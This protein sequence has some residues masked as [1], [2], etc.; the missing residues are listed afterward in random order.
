MKCII[1]C[2]GYDNNLSSN[3]TDDIP[4]GLLELSNE[5]VLLDS[6][7]EQLSNLSEL[8]K[9]Y[10]VTN[11]KYYISFMNWYKKTI[12]EKDIVIVNDNT[13]SKEAKLG[14][15]GDIKFVINSENIDDDILVLLG[16]ALFDFDINEFINYYRTYQVPIVA[17]LESN[18]IDPA[19]Y[20]VIKC[21]ASDDI[22]L[23]QEKPT[24]VFG[25][26]ISLGLYLFPKEILREFDNYLSAGNKA[27]SPGYFIE[28]LY[29]NTQIK[30][31]KIHG[32]YIA[33]KD[34]N[35]LCKAKETYAKRSL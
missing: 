23:M 21:T 11:D 8:D 15:I 18:N 32:S 24:K 4:S 27:T 22:K 14:A 6:T 25:N 2:A 16:D 1:L 31:C 10:I 33:I 3:S 9:I 30:V 7:L 20:G 5:K 28:Y 34:I 19:K 35:S 13:F 26:I 29:K 17:G 12:F